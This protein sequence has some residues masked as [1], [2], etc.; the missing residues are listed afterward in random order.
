MSNRLRTRIEQIRQA[1]Q[2][3]GGTL[4]M[5]AAAL[6][7]RLARVPIPGRRLRESLFRAIYG[8]K[9]SPLCESELGRP[10]GEF[11]SL[12]ELFT[13]SVPA[14]LRPIAQ[15]TH[16]ILCPCDGTVQTIGRATEHAV[17]TAKGIDYSLDTLL[18]GACPSGMSGA[19]YAVIFLSPTDCHRVFAPCAAEL[20]EVIHVPGSRL[21]VHPPYQRMEY[22]VFTTNE[23]VILHLRTGM[24]WCTLVLVAGWG[25]GNITHPFALRRSLSKRHV[26]R[27]VFDKPL[28]FE[29]GEWI[30]TFELGSTVILLLEPTHNVQPCLAPGA[31]VRYGQPAY[32]P[33]DPPAGDPEPTLSSR[34]ASI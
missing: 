30:A 18:A 15:D 6:A 10:L 1:R 8:H 34:G 11:R 16:H 24:G 19:N 17:L 22:P 2:I 33:S 5:G 3:H 9:Y 7:V 23:R 20:V 28:A 4:R 13:R 21:L 27:T 12:N 29:A 32:R 14:E 31:M 26:T 25:V